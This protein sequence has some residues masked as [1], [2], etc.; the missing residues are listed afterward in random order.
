MAVRII[1]PDV[2]EAI[3][4]ATKVGLVDTTGTVDTQT[5]AAV[6]AALNVQV[7]RDLPKY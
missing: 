4:L 7:T 5:M 1:R 2:K 6:V 3:M